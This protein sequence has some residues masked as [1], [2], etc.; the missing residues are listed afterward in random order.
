MSHDTVL[1]QTNILL[2]LD[3]AREIIWLSGNCWKMLYVTW[4]YIL[5]DIVSSVKT[6]R[7]ILLS[8]YY[9]MLL[10]NRVALLV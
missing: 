7:Y 3:V 4:F 8:N 5:N 2:A 10:L 6:F 1:A 9:A